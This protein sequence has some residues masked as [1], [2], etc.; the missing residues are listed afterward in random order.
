MF[1]KVLYVIVIAVVTFL[2]AG[3]FLP[4]SVHVERSIVIDRPVS[5]LFVVLNGFD[6]FPEWSA[7]S[8]RDPGIVYEFSG[9]K[10]GVGARMSWNGDPR[11]VGA[12]WQEVVESTPWSMVRMSRYFDQ[13]GQ[14]ESYFQITPEGGGA[15]VNWGFDASLVEGQGF[16]GGLLA[17]YFGLFFDKWIGSDYERGLER[18]KTYAEALPAADFSDLD[19]EIVEAVPL[20]ILYI[21]TDGREASVN[22]AGN[23]AAAYREITAFMAEHSIEMISEPMTI[24]RA[25]DAEDYEFDA[26]IPV[27][28]TDV[29]PS[30]SIRAGKSPSGRAVRVVHRGSYDRMAPSYEK[31]TAYMAAHGL[32]EGRVSWEHYISDPGQ[33]PV[34]EIITHIYFLVESE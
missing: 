24:T 9:P 6:S 27:S 32:K 30:G 29:E 2:I 13:Q 19:V 4:R 14:S 33:T 26:A 7:W 34:D 25:W 8:E 10:S 31:L 5:T 22:F 16:F 20:D 11:L 18:L 1:N 21:A 15:R 12:G 17:R 3:L 28:A 23:L